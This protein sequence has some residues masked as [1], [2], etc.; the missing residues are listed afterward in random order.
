M[1]HKESDL[2]IR[3]IKWFRY[4]YPAFALL[5]HHPKNEGHG[6]RRSGAIAKAEGVTAGVADIILHVPSFDLSSPVCCDTIATNPTLY[7]SLAIELK[8]PTGRQS[9]EQHQWQR[10]FEAS[11]GRYV[12]IRSYDDFVAEVTR[13]MLN[14]PLYVTKTV[15]ATHKQLIAEEDEQVRQQMKKFLNEE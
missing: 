15:T 12:I 1:K 2:Q 13:Y 6:D 4:Q 8:T 10:L 14:V 5:M 11:G 3:C 7:Y 9:P